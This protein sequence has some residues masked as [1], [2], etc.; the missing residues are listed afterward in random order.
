MQGVAA[1]PDLGGIDPAHRALL[2]VD[3]GKSAWV[4]APGKTPG[5]VLRDASEA[6][7]VSNPTAASVFSLAAYSTEDSMQV[8]SVPRA[9]TG[10]DTRPSAIAGTFYPG[11]PDELSKMVD[12]LLA[13]ADVEAEDWPAVMVPHAGLI[14]SGRLAASTLRHVRIPEIVIVIAPKHTRAGVEWA[15]APHDTWALPGGTLRSDPELARKLAEAIPGLELDSAAHQREHA[16]EVELPLLARLAPD[17]RV[18]GITIGAGDLARCRQFATG[19]ANVVRDMQPRPLLVISSD[20]NHFANDEE[21][22]RLD[23]IALDALETLDPAAVFDTVV[24]RHN[25]SMCGVRPAVIVMETLRQL[26]QL[27][28]CERVG[29]ATSAEVSGDKSRVVGYAGM[30]FGN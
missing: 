10:P 1:E 27:E 3:H 6:A 7:R 30:L 17:T 15:V 19:L 8:S 28:K 4:F 20:M 18:V 5:D 14:Y 22:R 21:N 13:G 12:D 29:Y 9:R 26:G 16:I 25:I 2:V 24:T 11:D 23:A